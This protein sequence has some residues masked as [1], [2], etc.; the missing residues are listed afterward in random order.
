VTPFESF[1]DGRLFVINLTKRTDRLQHFNAMC[2][3]TG[4]TSV[5]RFEA[6]GDLRDE[7]GRIN[8]NMGCVA[9]HR[10]LLEMQIANQWPR[11]FIFE[12][13]AD[14]IYAD[15]HER[16]ERFERELPPTWQMCYL[17]AGYF[18]APIARVSPHVIRAGRLATTS[19]YGITL[20][21]AKLIAPTLNGVG[22]IDSLVSAFHREVDTFIISP[23]CFVQFPSFSDLQEQH[24]GNAQSMLSR[25]L[26]ANL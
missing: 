7:S 21:A 10:A 4:L 19:S 3:R 24:S 17:G 11:L 5:Q 9:S 15:F 8:G 16:W 14:C 23:R 22:P 26:E 20:E 6:V 25:E 2:Q 13:D 1:F 12:D 18:E